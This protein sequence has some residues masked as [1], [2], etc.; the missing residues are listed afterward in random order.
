MTL[1]QHPLIHAMKNAGDAT[2]R[3]AQW[4]QVTNYGDNTNGLTQEMWGL[5]DA[6]VQ[7]WTGVSRLNDTNTLNDMTHPDRPNARRRRDL[8][9]KISEALVSLPIAYREQVIDQLA[10]GKGAE[11]AH[12]LQITTDRRIAFLLAG[13]RANVDTHATAAS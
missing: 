5:T 12:A 1:T 3:Q 2:R 7:D 13:I 9:M 4:L 8:R 10:D 6:L 11:E